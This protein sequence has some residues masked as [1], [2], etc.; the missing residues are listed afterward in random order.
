MINMLQTSNLKD[1]WNNLAINQVT[2]LLLF[3]NKS[4]GF[5]PQ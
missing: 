1:P 4:E 2:Q 3:L 5:S